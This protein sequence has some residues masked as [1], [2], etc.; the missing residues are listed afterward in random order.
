MKPKRLNRFFHRGNDDIMMGFEGIN[1]KRAKT[2]SFERNLSK[3]EKTFS[4]DGMRCKCEI[5]KSFER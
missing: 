2:L 5:E 1:R 3:G 4:S